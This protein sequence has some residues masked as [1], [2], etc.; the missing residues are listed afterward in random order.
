MDTTL[1]SNQRS[2]WGSRLPMFYGWVILPVASLALFTSGP[3]QTYTISVFVDPIIED[4]GWSRTLV[5]SLYTA[6]SLSAAL[7]MVLVGHLLDRFGARIMLI[8]VAGCF[9]FSVLFMS[10]VNHPI[11]LYLGFAALRIF[12]QGSLTLIPTT[13]ISLWF[14]R[15]RARATA[16]STVGM[17]GS[18][19]ILPPITLMLIAELGW[20]NAWVILAFMIW[21][22]LL[23]PVATVIRRSPESVGLHP[24]GA[25][26]PSAALGEFAEPRINHEV[27]WTL[28]ESFHTRTFW[29]LLFSGSS[30][31]LISTAL[32][33]HQGS[34]FATKGLDASLAALVLTVMAGMALIGS[35]LAGILNDRVPNRYVLA[36]SQFILILAMVWT[37]ALSQSWEALVYGGLLGMG[38]GLFMN[39][40]T[41]I[42]PN[43]FGRRHLGS[44]RGMA[45]TSMVGFAALGPMPFGLLFDLTGSYNIAII[46]F[47]AL[48]T[49]CG[50]A[51][52]LARPPGKDN[53]IMAQTIS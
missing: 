29:L 18:Q 9:G 26:D 6:G 48:P 43:Y 50:I 3:G 1:Q 35:F 47:L 34:L 12:G 16:I 33:F 36:L 20:R 5:S 45:T 15:F 7:A 41:V 53:V 28:R 10:I 21:G 14:I 27:D 46:S 49:A 51:A 44:I 19:A 24:D 32:V 40:F 11:E 31:S 23:I 52:L 22:L 30:L 37:F 25:P 39:T 38:G 8:G 17:T 13:L 4:M 2:F 42:W